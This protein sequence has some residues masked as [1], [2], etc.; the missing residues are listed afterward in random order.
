MFERMVERATRQAERRAKAHVIELT[1][2]FRAEL[3]GGI[4]A[5]AAEGGV[6]LMGR[7]LRRRLALEPALRWMRLR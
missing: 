6:R 7:N 3:P 4:T 5:E 1:Q 2:R